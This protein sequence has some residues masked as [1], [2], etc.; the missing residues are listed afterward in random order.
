MRIGQANNAFIFPGVGLGALVAQARVVTDDMFA[1]AAA[2]LAAE[3]VA[4]TDLARGASS[5][6]SASC[7]A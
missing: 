7:G 4:P 1:A 5:R 6:G 3:V 2:R